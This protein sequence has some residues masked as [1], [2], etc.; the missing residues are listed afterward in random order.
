MKKST[1]PNVKQPIL[2]ES[3]RKDS[4]QYSPSDCDDC[5]ICRGMKKAEEEG[6]ALSFEELQ[7]HFS[8]AKYAKI[9]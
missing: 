7:V 4:E 1:H 6:R 9:D 8:K 3:S 5:A 2:G